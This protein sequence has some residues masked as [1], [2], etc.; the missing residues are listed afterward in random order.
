MT[1]YGADVATLVVPAFGPFSY[2]GST[3][4]YEWSLEGATRRRWLYRLSRVALW[5]RA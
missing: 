5:V 3:V 2:V 1:A 4:R